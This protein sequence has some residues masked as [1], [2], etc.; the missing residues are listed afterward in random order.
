MVEFIGVEKKYPNGT[1]ALKDISFRIDKG[2][3]VFIIG[4]SGSGKSTMLKLMMKEE[5]PTAG[6]VFVNGYDVASLSRKEI[7][8]LRR[9][10][11]VVFQDFRLLPNKTVYENVAFAMQITEA[12]PKEIRRQVPMA[13]AL[14]G[15]SR[16]ANVCPGQLSGGEQQRTA[17]ARALVNN[18]S[19]LIADEPTGNLDPENSWEIIRLLAEINNRGTTVIVATHEKSIVDAMKK[20]V[21]ALNRGVLVR[22][23]QKG[24]YEDENKNFPIHV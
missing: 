20:R 10:L 7:P 23:Q 8:S 5:E 15:L 16:K 3:F 4:S 13:L 9:S 12:T 6:Q 2:E 11:G 22:D 17:L 24:L 19:I 14:V 18:P 21:I 1:V